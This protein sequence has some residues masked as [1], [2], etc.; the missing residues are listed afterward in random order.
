MVHKGWKR[1]LIAELGGIVAF[2]AAVLA[3]IYYPGWWDSF[4]HEMTG[5]ARSSAHVIV[6]ASCGIVTYCLVALLGWSLERYAQGPVFAPI[7]SFFG[8]II[9]LIKAALL[10]WALLYVALFFPLSPD[11]RSDFK[12]SFIIPRLTQPNAHFDEQVRDTLPWFVRPFASPVL[13][14]HRLSTS[15]SPTENNEE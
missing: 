14:R 6:M 13:K 12:H 5:V 1:G 4:V 11:L 9:G 7:D 3:A 15:F 2:Y 8:A 10:F